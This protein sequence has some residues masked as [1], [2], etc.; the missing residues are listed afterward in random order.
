MNA[1]VLEETIA[2][3]LGAPV[4]V[5]VVHGDTRVHDHPDDHALG[6]LALTR[7]LAA[8]GRTTDE[9]TAWPCRFASV[10]HSKGVAIAV[11]LPRGDRARGLGVDL[12]L[13]RPVKAGLAGIFCD[14]RER[15]WLA[16]LP[17]AERAVATLQLWTAKEALYK[18]DA[19]QGDSIV[20]EYGVD[21]PAL[22]RG[23]RGAARS[24]RLV[25]LRTGGASLSVALEPEEDGH[26]A[27]SW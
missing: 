10:S 19:A 22:A 1:A 23:G 16:D 4:R 18:A 9:V 11:A 15:A 25:S 2:A 21:V 26:V 24:T 6:K 14:D 8:A 20:A 13:D 5:A 17:A 3:A 27:T 7:A 12:E